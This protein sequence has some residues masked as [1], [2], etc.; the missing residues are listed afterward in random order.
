MI[1]HKNITTYIQREIYNL[2]KEYS[3]AKTYV[4][5]VIIFSKTF[6]DHL[7]HFNKIFVLLQ[8][9]NITL[10]TIKTYLEYF[11]IILLDQKVDNLELFTIENKLKTI[12]KMFFLKIF[13]NLKTYLNAIN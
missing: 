10:K 1:R 9:M 12:T 6:K 2:L 5:D 3:F 7:E 4:D 13:K 8:K 11:I